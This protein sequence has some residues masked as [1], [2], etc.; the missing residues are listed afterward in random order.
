MA[1]R[2]TRVDAVGEGDG[3]AATTAVWARPATCT[4]GPAIA[5]PAAIT[6]VVVVAGTFET[7]FFFGAVLVV[8]ALVVAVLVVATESGR[9]AAAGTAVS[10]E[11][12]VPSIETSLG[13]VSDP[14]PSG[15]STT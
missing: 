11:V 1:T 9:S 4:R 5:E 2:A 7:V 15:R 8:M 3:A 10:G 6:T 12:L 14:T 13:W